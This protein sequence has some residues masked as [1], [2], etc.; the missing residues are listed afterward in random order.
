MA[1]VGS[2]LVPCGRLRVHTITGVFRFV[3]VP[4]QA[5]VVRQYMRFTAKIQSGKT[6]ATTILRALQMYGSVNRA[7]LVE[8]HCNI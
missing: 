1:D 7:K 2:R 4:D 8:T 6:A 5:G 3:D